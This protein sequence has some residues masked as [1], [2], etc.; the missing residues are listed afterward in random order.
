MSLEKG[1]RFLVLTAV[2]FSGS[3][4]L[5][6]EDYSVDQNKIPQMI[7]EDF[8]QTSVRKGVKSYVFS[9]EKA[10]KYDGLNQL[11][12]KAIKFEEYNAAGQVITRGKADSATI[13]TQTEDVTVDGQVEAWSEKQKATLQAP[14]LDWKQSDKRLV[15]RPGEVVLRKDS[16]SVLRGKGLQIDFRSNELT[17]SGPLEGSYQP[18][19]SGAVTN[20]H[21]SP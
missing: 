16:G 7:L 17:L 10:E 19:E 8:Q 5:K 15:T 18:E 14:G 12:L 4:S 2:V 6:Y 1:F 3:C 13:L 21:L 11:R 20:P 9:G